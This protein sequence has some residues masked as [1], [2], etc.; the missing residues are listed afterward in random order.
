MDGAEGSRWV[1]TGS[2]GPPLVAVHS[3]TTE[4]TNYER[5]S[6]AMGGQCIYSLLPPDPDSTSLPRRVGQWVDYH[7]ATL[8][9][10]DLEPPWRF[11]GWS[12]GGILAAELAR[13]RHGLGQDVAY[14]G[15]V[16][17]L[18][19]RLTPRS[20]EQ[21]VWYHLSQ[22]AGLS[23]GQ[24]SRYLYHKGRS[25]LRSR[26]PRSA[27]A[28]TQVL[29]AARLRKAPGPKRPP[30]PQHPLK[31]AVHV[32]YLNYQGPAIDEP[33]H[34]YVVEE[35]AKHSRGPVLGWLPFLH[36]GYTLH[37]VAGDH[38]TIFDPAHVDSIAVAMTADLAALPPFSGAQG[39]LNP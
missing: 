14:V 38:L 29:H 33:V 20:T 22:A 6:H 19:P 13:R 27:R 9:T 32:A 5:L 37:A 12:F 2:K 17:T 21:Y 23:E 10:L 24:R 39:N 16:D 18:R 1:R 4:D 15:M 30:K 28:A 8:Q 34:F 7:D 26:F 3:W 25:L 31:I 35:S 11:V 36:G